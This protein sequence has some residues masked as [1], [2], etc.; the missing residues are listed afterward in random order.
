MRA[1]APCER[2][3][4]KRGTCRPRTEHAAARRLK[5]CMTTRRALAPARREP[6]PG[7]GIETARGLLGPG[8]AI[9]VGAALA[10]ELLGEQLNRPGLNLVDRYGDVYCGGGRLMEGGAQEA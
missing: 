3:E 1:P 6:D 7:C 8:P 4:T 9:V 10:E 5:R 2:L